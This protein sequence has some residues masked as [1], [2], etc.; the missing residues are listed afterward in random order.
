MVDSDLVSILE[1]GDFIS[2]AL[3]ELYLSV[4][5]MFLSEASVPD[6]D[7]RGLPRA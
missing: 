4:G 2:E 3:K 6:R 7:R 5:Q 1:N